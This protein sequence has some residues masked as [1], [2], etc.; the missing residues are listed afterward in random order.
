MTNKYDVKKLRESF[1]VKI[2]WSESSDFNGKENIVFD[3]EKAITDLE[4]KL[5]RI[6]SEM[7]GKD[8]GYYKTKYELLLFGE[9][10]YQGRADLGDYN[11]AGISIHIDRWLKWLLKNENKNFMA[12]NSLVQFL[13]GDISEI[14]DEVIEELFDEEELQRLS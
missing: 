8:K 11:S 4:F 3:T 6:S 13:F 5:R 9:V 12:L 14:S 10:F 7:Y 1:S 2:L